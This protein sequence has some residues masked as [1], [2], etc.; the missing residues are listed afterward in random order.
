[1]KDRRKLAAEQQALTQSHQAATQALVT[2][3]RDTEKKRKASHQAPDHQE[4]KSAL[5][6][7]VQLENQQRKTVQGITTKMTQ[8]KERLAQFRKQEQGKIDIQTQEA[9]DLKKSKNEHQDRDQIA[10]TKR[11]KEKMRKDKLVKVPLLEKQ[12]K[13]Q[14]K[15]IS[16][17]EKAAKTAQEAFDKASANQGRF[18]IQIKKWKAASINTQLIR[19]REEIESLTFKKEEDPSVQGKI[20]AAQKRYEVLLA[21]YQGAKN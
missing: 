2:A 13:P 17:Q 19:T 12:L 9:T 3:T 1:M 4:K 15:N 21:Q 16:H 14:L 7:A 20:A 6:A 18:A 11:E 10:K 8:L 5:A